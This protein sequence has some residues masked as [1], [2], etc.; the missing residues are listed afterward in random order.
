MRVVLEF[1]G[2]DARSDYEKRGFFPMSFFILPSRSFLRRN[3]GDRDVSEV[4]KVP[5]KLSP[6]FKYVLV[7][8]TSVISFCTLA[9]PM[10]A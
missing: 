5:F 10:H 2:L 7:L 6:V 9:T 8:D 1:C 4:A 3:I